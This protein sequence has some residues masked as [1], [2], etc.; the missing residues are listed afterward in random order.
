MKMVRG[1]RRMMMMMERR[2]LM[3]VVIIINYDK[4]GVWVMWKIFRMNKKK[5]KRSG[6][7]IKWMLMMNYLKNINYWILYYNKILI[8]F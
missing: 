6:I 3:V 1:G 4:M 7:G 5:R 8:L 2:K